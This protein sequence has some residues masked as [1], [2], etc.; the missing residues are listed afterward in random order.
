MPQKPID[1]NIDLNDLLGLKRQK[2]SAPDPKALERALSLVNGERGKLG[3]HPLQGVPTLFQV[4]QAHAADMDQRG[5]LGNAT[6]E[7][8]AIS[9]K[10]RRA[11]YEGRTEVLVA[12]GAEQPDGVIREWLANAQYQKH[13]MSESYQH[14]GIG[15]SDGLWTFILGAPQSLQL[16]D[17][18]ELRAQ[19]LKLIND[20][21]QRANLPLLE[22]SDA[23][24]TAA[25][26]HS[27]D[28][29]QR[30]YFGT[31]SPSGETIA[32]RAQKAGFTGRSVGC[33]TKGPQSPDEAVV[34]LLGTSRGNLLHP[35]VRF[36][37]VATTAGRWTVILGTR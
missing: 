8:D 37:G 21:R 35:D 36:L 17:V 13:L 14:I 16:S 30:D 31:T 28:M 9:G 7:G 6:P 23:L 15:T 24:G 12:D 27:A 19:V 1:V 34:A 26:E 22:L 3:L 5:Y 18:R 4:A 25:Q 11:G 29:A 10:A 20:Q 2:Q 33:L 32:A